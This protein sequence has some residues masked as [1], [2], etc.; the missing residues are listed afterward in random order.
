M[1]PSGADGG[2]WR[3]R[4]ERTPLSASFI[5]H[6]HWPWVSCP[7]PRPLAT[8]LGSRRH[9]APV[10][11]TPGQ[12]MLNTAPLPQGRL[13]SAL[14]QAL[15]VADPL[16]GLCQPSHMSQSSVTVNTGEFIATFIVSEQRFHYE[17]NPK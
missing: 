7:H 1:A 9:P 6:C 17:K 15:R 12:L 16:P 10:Y 13:P 8:S 2:G 11:P 14:S 5:R 3:P 4:A